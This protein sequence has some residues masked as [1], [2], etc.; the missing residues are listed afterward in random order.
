MRSGELHGKG[1]NKRK[2]VSPSCREEGTRYTARMALREHKDSYDF[3]VFSLSSFVAQC[4]NCQKLCLEK[5]ERMID[6]RSR[7]PRGWDTLFKAVAEERR[8]EDFDL[9][10]TKCLHL[11]RVCPEAHVIESYEK[12]V[13]AK[14]NPALLAKEFSLQE[15]SRCENAADTF[16]KVL[17]SVTHKPSKVSFDQGKDQVASEKPGSPSDGAPTEVHRKVLEGSKSIDNEILRRWSK[18][19]QDRLN[20]EEQGILRS[21][22]DVAELR[23]SHRKADEETGASGT[24]PRW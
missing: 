16:S 8:N 4:S 22:K 14:Q 21:E 15:M 11:A 13:G 12:A 24:T 23:R 5:T 2:G 19:R 1:G 9:C 10:E 17:F 18:S 3:K 7:A 20:M 6:N